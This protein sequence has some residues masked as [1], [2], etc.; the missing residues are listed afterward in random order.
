MTYTPTGYTQY[1][2]FTIMVLNS[3]GSQYAS[4]FVDVTIEYDSFELTYYLYG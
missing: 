2:S 1:R 3:D 4:H